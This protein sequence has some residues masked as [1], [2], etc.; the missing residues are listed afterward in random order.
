VF[1]VVGTGAI[2]G[3]FRHAV[4]PCRINRKLYY[5]RE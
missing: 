3:R 4:I 5:L 1:V 2:G